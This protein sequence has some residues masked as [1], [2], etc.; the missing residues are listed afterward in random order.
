M[1]QCNSQEGAFNALWRR[2]LG[3]IIAAPFRCMFSIKT[4]AVLFALCNV[5]CR[6]SAILLLSSLGLL[7]HD[8]AQAEE[9]EVVPRTTGVRGHFWLADGPADIYSANQTAGNRFRLGAE[10]QFGSGY[11][12]IAGG[13]L[14]DLLSSGETS[15]GVG[16]ISRAGWDFNF[17]Y[18]LVPDRLWIEYSFQLGTV[19][20]SFI[21][22]HVGTT[23]HGLNIGYRFYNAD[24]FNIGV[25]AGFLHIFS[26]TVGTYDYFN[27]FVGNA[28][29]PG[30]NVWSIS[31]VVGFDVGGTP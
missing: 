31:A 17:G 22:G 21:G 4:R 5:R 10:A 13:T 30:A 11:R 20:G 26:E 16:D 18:F 8:V 12:F 9:F 7:H 25:E 2:R 15:S 28:T 27:N 3:I 19:H 14:I 29:Y 23:G 6:V 1:G 24:N